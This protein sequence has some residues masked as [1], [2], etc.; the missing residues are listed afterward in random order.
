MTKK[1]SHRVDDI[2]DDTGETRVFY[3]F[4]KGIVWVGGN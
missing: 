4:K 1:G 2:T 3:A